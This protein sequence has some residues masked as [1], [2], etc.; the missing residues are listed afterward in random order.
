MFE[1]CI[2]QIVACNFSD[3]IVCIFIQVSLYVF[4]FKFL[5]IYLFILLTLSD[6]PL[7][8]NLHFYLLLSLFYC[9]K[10][11]AVIYKKCF[12]IYLK[13]Q[14]WSML[15]MPLSHSS[16][17]PIK[18]TETSVWEDK[19]FSRKVALPLGEEEWQV[20]QRGQSW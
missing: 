16:E 11:T 19:L 13:I 10:Y 18:V 15:I 17:A 4:L 7:K 14:E 9:C 20:Q 1:P 2:D 6:F 5:F 8:N 12:V 3:F